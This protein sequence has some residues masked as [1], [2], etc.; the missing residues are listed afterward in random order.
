ME[1]SKYLRKGSKV[2]I[3]LV[4]GD[5]AVTVGMLEYNGEEAVISKVCRKKTKGRTVYDGGLGKSK[6][7]TQAE[8]VVYGFELEDVVSEYGVP[9][10]FTKDMFL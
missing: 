4:P 5:N 1:E 9:Y 10:T 6:R 2:T 8:S 7:V 3:N